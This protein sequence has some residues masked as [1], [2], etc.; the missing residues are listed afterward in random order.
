MT[1]F[2]F[3]VFFLFKKRRKRPR[4]SRLSL[5][6]LFSLLRASTLHETTASVSSHVRVIVALGGSSSTQRHRGRSGRARRRARVSFFIDIDVD[7]CSLAFSL[8]LLLLC[9][10]SPS[11]GQA[12]RRGRVRAEPRRRRRRPRRKRKRR[13]CGAREVEKGKEKKNAFCSTSSMFWMLALGLFRLSRWLASASS[14][15]IRIPG[16]RARRAFCGSTLKRLETS[17]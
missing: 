10:T 6:P 7:L 16:A 8:L 14:G 5:H 9:C 4:R 15:P 2:Q 3:L 12:P 1:L 11:L 13:E 17:F